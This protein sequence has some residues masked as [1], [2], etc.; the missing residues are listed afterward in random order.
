MEREIIITLEQMVSIHAGKPDELLVLAEE[1]MERFGTIP[2]A[3]P[4]LMQKLGL[5]AEEIR[6]ILSFYHYPISDTPVRCRVEVCGAIS[7]HLK[8]TDQLLHELCEV[9]SV[10]P[11]VIR[12]DNQLLI[13]RS[14]CLSH[15]EQAPAVSV[16]GEP[17]AGNDLQSLVVRIRE[18]LS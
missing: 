5:A 1:L 3:A 16:N 2:E 18:A 9:F 14:E 4:P 15:C 7:C 8:K 10:E 6:S 11:G 17:H 13:S 12:Q